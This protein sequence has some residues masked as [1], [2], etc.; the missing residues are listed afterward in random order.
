MYCKPDKY[1]I[2]VE[3]SL[4]LIYVRTGKDNFEQEI[5][6]LFNN[7]HNFY[8]RY[9]LSSIVFYFSQPSPDSTEDELGFLT[10]LNFLFAVTS[11][12]DGPPILYVCITPGYGFAMTTYCT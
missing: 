9:F 6:N 8:L 12:I 1:T 2:T 11:A 4:E 3:D 10:L 5:K 7:F